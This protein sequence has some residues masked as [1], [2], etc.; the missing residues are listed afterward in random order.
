MSK[1]ESRS[2]LTKNEMVSPLTKFWLSPRCVVI[3]RVM[4]SLWVMGD[5]WGPA[6]WAFTGENRL[7]NRLKNNTLNRLPWQQS[8]ASK[9][10][11][12]LYFIC[13]NQKPT[14]Y[15]IIDGFYHNLLQAEN[16]T[17]AEPDTIDVMDFGNVIII[18]IFLS[19]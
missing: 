4:G 16:S 18:A 7:I 10:T 3:S 1:Y 14:M 15:E 12:R 13:N 17:D 5:L 19:L 2:M 11:G 8:L 9:K 6:A